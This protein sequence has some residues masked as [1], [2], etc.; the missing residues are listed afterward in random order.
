[1]TTRKTSIEQRTEILGD[2]KYAQ[3]VLTKL[4][5]AVKEGDKGM[6]AYWLK[7]LTETLPSI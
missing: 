4:E 2:I 1:M 7:D 3:W 5:E 6:A